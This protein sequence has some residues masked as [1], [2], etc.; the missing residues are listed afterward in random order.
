MTSLFLAALAAPAAP[1]TSAPAQTEVRYRLTHD[2]GIEAWT[3]EVAITRLPR[4]ARIA[5]AMSDWGG[6]QD[7]PR[8]HVELIET[9][10]P[11]RESSP[12]TGRFVPDAS[13][14]RKGKFSIRYR[15]PL[16]ALHSD[17]QKRIGLLPTAAEG[18]AFGY[19]WNT[20][21]QVN[22]QD[23]PL[24]AQRTIELVAPEGMT[25]VTG[26]AGLSQGRQAAV[27][28][29]A[30]GNGPIAFGTPA[31]IE[32]SQ[33]A[34]FSADVYQF[35][36]G[37]DVT[38]TVAKV[39]CACVPALESALKFPARN[40][41]RAFITDTQGGGMGSDYGL[42][43]GVMEDAPKD[44]GESP[45][46]KH[47][48]THELFHD[49]LG[50]ALTETD[51]SL[52]WFKEGCSLW[53]ATA[54]GLVDRPYFARRLLELEQIE[55][56]RS[57]IGQVAFADNSVLWRDGDGPNETLAYTGAPLLALRVDAELRSRGRPGLLQLIRDLLKSEQ[58]T[59]SQR[60]L[61]DWLESNGL[62]QRYKTSF[63]GTDLPDVRQSLL[64][65][66]YG[67]VKDSEE[68]DADNQRLD[69]FFSFKP[70]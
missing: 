3:I 48:I 65:A 27:L 62:K 32:H 8:P 20:L 33:Q 67:E 52:V 21:L 28:D 68:L 69:Q 24:A 15:I 22:D 58:R 11:L 14:I 41:Y 45:W 35:G 26:W 7:R 63:Q 25:I 10:S 56:Q 57:S 36:K 19:S 23:V 43:I 39:L 9:S 60:D 44:H 38:K 29:T 50:I 59:F 1:G 70:K 66:G 18:Y 30:M 55:A 4:N 53:Q 2:P 51:S 17:E 47:H 46:L 12:E 31:R 16:T 49:W 42:R 37:P 40:P 5:F 64:L 54:S 6:W 61:K 34:N 13:K